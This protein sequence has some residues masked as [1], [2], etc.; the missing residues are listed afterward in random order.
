MTDSTTQMGA[1]S[2]T[3]DVK[4]ERKAVSLMAIGFGIVGLDRFI[5]NPLFPTMQQDLG[6]SYQ[7]LG[8]ISA[9]FALTWGLSSIFSGGL[10]DRI[11][12][13]RV[14][15]PSVLFFSILVATTGLAAGLV[16]LLIVRAVMGLAEGAYV[17]SSIV[18]TVEASHPKRIGLNVGIQQMAAPLIGLGLGPLIAVALLDVL[19]SWHWVFAVAAIPGLIIAVIMMKV[20]R[21]DTPAPMPQGVKREARFG[22]VLKN[23]NVIFI[24]ASMCCYL[25]TLITLSAFMPSYLTDHLGFGP[26]DMGKVLAGIGLGS[27]IGMVALPAL[28]DKVGRKPV[29]VVALLIEFVALWFLGGIG[30]DVGALFAVLFVATF[31][32][33]GVVAIS[34]GPL[35][36]GSVSPALTATATGLVVG[37][38]EIVGGALAPALAGGLA[39]TMGITVIIKIGLIAIGIA[40]P[41][42]LFGL[43]DVK[44]KT[45]H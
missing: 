6:L 7:D 14:I 26:I 12:R 45:T 42:V 17:P 41:L 13:K 4:Y 24:T 22:P 19:P 8:I 32:N 39:D 20:L 36:S 25:A 18:T 16:S 3:H 27:F 10:A 9:V 35:T 40:I 15:I 44:L 11:G 5:I 43:R 37:I 29:I 30:A 38:G 31:M 28:S 33:A 2:A 23:R 21:P 34:V 1:A